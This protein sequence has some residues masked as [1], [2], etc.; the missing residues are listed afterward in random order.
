MRV[1]G[2]NLSVS[3]ASALLGGSPAMQRS[4][5]PLLRALRLRLALF[6]AACM[7]VA[8]L[9]AAVIGLA[10]SALEPEAPL[11]QAGLSLGVASALL[12]AI[13][14]A[15]AV[16]GAPLLAEP[17][18]RKIAEAED[19]FGAVADT[20]PGIL[21]VG[22]GSGY[23]D[24][25]SARFYEYSGMPPG[26]ARGFGWSAVIH[27]EDRARIQ[28]LL[29]QPDGNPPACE[30]QLRL[31]QRNGS[32]RWF[33]IRTHAIPDGEPSLARWVGIA[34][35]IDDLKQAEVRLSQLSMQLMQ[36]E[37]RERR[38]IA[39]EIHDTTVQ[40]LAAVA[41]E[42]DQLRSGAIATPEA[43]AESLAEAHDLVGQSLQ[44]LRTLSYFFH[45]PMLDELG[46]ASAIRWYARGLAKRT[47][48]RIALEIPESM[49]R[50][51]EAVES[52]LFRVVQEALANVHRHSGSKEARIRMRVGADGISL[53]IRDYGKGIAA[54]LASAGGD[55]GAPLGVGIPGMRL[56][57]QQVGGSLR[58][59]TS[60]LGTAVIATVR[61]TID[62]R[63]AAA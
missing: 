28:D 55:D 4:V 14:I 63:K 62:E 9:L 39:R 6:A 24:I 5:P 54:L 43:I 18:R 42:I 2:V 48:L 31:R 37:D 57:L 15:M 36:A 56:R 41:L 53:E 44:E 32:Y 30:Y 51:S 16:L 58:I 34:T 12:L 61:T 21:F 50:M 33:A 10:P 47:G 29:V 25:V 8:L 27:P 17:F 45:P 19:R 38:R 7:A 11:G 22:H 35:D 13:G 59:E 20:I 26:S 46:L 60:S 1:A 49:P 52:A 3:A 40:N 23:C